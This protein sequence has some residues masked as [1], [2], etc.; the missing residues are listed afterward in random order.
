MALMGDGYGSEAHLLRWLGRHRGELDCHVL[1]TTGG[2]H[3]RW[4][5]FGFDRS[6]KWP[7][8]E[9][10]GIEFLAPDGQTR[11]AWQKF[12]PQSGSAPNWD[13]VAQLTI[14]GVAEWMLIEAK[15][16][17]GEL[18]S[19]CRAKPQGGLDQIRAALADTKRALSV[20]DD[21]DWLSPYY[22]YCNRLAVLHFLLNRCGISARLLLIYFT[23]DDGKGIRKCPQ[24]EA[25]WQPALKELDL[26]VG[27]SPRHPLTDRIHQLFLPVSRP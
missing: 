18:A 19:S 20:P 4:L 24:D 8:A 22:Q 15:A 17:V 2:Q 7:D 5:D 23:G 16:H 6:K 10:T 1:T 26:H 21:R 3:I 11:E 27:L 12:W 25:D 14:N 13:A 9:W